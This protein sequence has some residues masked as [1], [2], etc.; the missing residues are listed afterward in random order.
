MVTKNAPEFYRGLDVSTSLGSFQIAISEQAPETSNY[1]F[2][3]AKQGALDQ[4]KVFRITTDQ[5]QSHNT[6]QPIEVV[7]I[8]G[9]K[10]LGEKLEKIPHEN[11][12]ISNLRHK[13]WVVSTAR[14]QPGE[15]YKSFFICMRDEPELDMGGSRVEDR[16][17]FAAFGEVVSGFSV[18]ESIFSK[19]E[20]DE[21]L[22]DLIHIDS[23]KPIERLR[24][25][26]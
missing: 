18:V 15:V 20:D 25:K 17:G 6:E 21:F 2:D 13:K 23:I 3:L 16:L 7:Q 1:F 11:T 19:A 4:A 24:A 12:G 5:N 14:F 10:G 26:R 22:V 8:G 9:D